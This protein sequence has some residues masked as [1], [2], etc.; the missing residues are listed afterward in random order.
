[1]MHSTPLQ[2]ILGF[3]KGSASDDIAHLIAPA[4]GEELKRDVQIKRL[5]GESGT[6]GAQAVALSRPD[7]DC[8]FMATLGTHALA[9]H[10]REDL[11]Y[12]PLEDF[13]PIGLLTHSPMILACTPS[14]SVNNALELIER[15]RE[16][17]NTLAYGTSAIGGAPHLS[18]ELFQKRTGIRLKHAP[19][20]QTQQLY[21][22]LLQG[23]IALSFN[24]IMSMRPHCLSGA[25][26]GLGITSRERSAVVPQ[27]P[28]LH[29]LGIVDCEVSNWLGLV[30][31]KATPAAILN[32]LSKAA[33]A[34]LQRPLIQKTLAA[35]GLTASGSDPQFFAQFLMQ[36][37]NRWQ[38][39][40]KD[41]SHHQT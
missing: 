27:I 28:T 25:L 32:T 22:D 13:S 24:N 20:E 21:A 29:E 23:H 35:S 9:P 19:Y 7:G 41:F 26:K 16:Q 18:A 36:E 40:V 2:I 39:I 33:H 10:M 30:A 31:P 11:A 15:A 12:H 37:F 17:P 14:L 6:L 1:M 4:L 34:A 8:L 3:S 38:P 5:T